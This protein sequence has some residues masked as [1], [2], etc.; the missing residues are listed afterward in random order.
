GLL[1]RLSDEEAWASYSLVAMG[2]RA[3][4]P[5]AAAIGLALAVA[6]GLLA[7]AAWVS[8][9]GAGSVRDR[10]VASL[11]LALAAAL[12]ASPIVWLHYFVLLLVPVSLLSPRLSLLWLVPLALWPLPQTGWPG[13]DPAKLALALVVI[14]VVVAAASLP[15]ARKGEALPPGALRRLLAWTR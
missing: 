3:H 15:G 13:G 11:A 10:E 12:A 8:R 9:N 4:L 1:R 2:M 7:A 6:G 5:Q 14:V